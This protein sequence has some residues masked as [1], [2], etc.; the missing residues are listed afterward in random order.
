L[1]K[2]SN[3]ETYKGEIEIFVPAGASFRI[4]GDLG[5]D[6]RLDSDFEMVTHAFGSSERIEAKINGGEGPEIWIE[7]H[8]GTIRLRTGDQ[9]SAA[10]GDRPDTH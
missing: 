3:L 9:E 6:A 2:S 8:K 7:S 1:T 5:D 10:N 4:S